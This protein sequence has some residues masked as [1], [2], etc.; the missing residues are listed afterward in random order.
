MLG[1]NGQTR[2]FP[3]SNLKCSLSSTALDPT[4]AHIYPLQRTRAHVHAH[5]QSARESAPKR[6]CPTLL[7]FATTAHSSSIDALSIKNRYKPDASTVNPLGPSLVSALVSGVDPAMVRRCR[8][9]RGDACDTCGVESGA[10][11]SGGAAVKLQFCI[12][13]KKR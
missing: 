4:C 2:K 11:S 13:C 6:K 10:G 12:Q 8:R 3:C 5:F 9:V 7:S 1:S